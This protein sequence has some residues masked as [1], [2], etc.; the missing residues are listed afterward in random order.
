MTRVWLAVFVAACLTGCAVLRH[1][2]V[3][4]GVFPEDAAFD[5]GAI[6]TEEWA[7]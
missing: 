7:Q 2:A 6:V 4:R 3:V 1:D 5:G